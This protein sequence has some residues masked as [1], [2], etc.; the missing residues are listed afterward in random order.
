MN[1]AYFRGSVTVL[2]SFHLL[3]VTASTALADFGTMAI[4]RSLL[5]VLVYD[6]QCKENSA[7]E[8]P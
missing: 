7:T 4:D 5:L 3:E 2:R 6:R 8:I 1:Q